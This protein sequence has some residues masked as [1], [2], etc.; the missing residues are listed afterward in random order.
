MQSSLL[1]QKKVLYFEDSVQ[2]FDTEKHGLQE[3][4]NTIERKQTK[5]NIFHDHSQALK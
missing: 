5:I 4:I 1:I 2:N 3:N